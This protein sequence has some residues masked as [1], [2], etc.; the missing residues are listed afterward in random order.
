[1]TFCTFQGQALSYAVDFE[2]GLLENAEKLALH[3]FGKRFVLLTDSIVLPLY[4]RA[5]DERLKACGLDVYLASFPAGERH[6]T[7]STKER[8]EDDLLRQGFGRDTVLLALGGGAV[9]DMGGFLAS[10]YCRGIPWVA[11]PTTLLGMVDACLGGKTGVNTPFGKNLVGSIYQP[12]HLAIDPQT[13]ATL[14]LKEL[15]N[16][17]VEMIKHAC[18]KDAAYFSFLKAH[19]SHLWQRPDLLQEAIWR[20]FF[21]KKEIVELDER[22]TGERFLLN[23]GHTIGH[24]LEFAANYQMAHGEAVA[25][26]MVVEGYVA[27]KRGILEQDSFLQMWDLLKAYGLPL[28]PAFPLDFKRI[29]EALLLDKKALQKAPRLILLEAI[30]RTQ[31]G[32]CHAV[33]MEE[34]EQALH[35][36]RHDLFG[37]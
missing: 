21:I 33:M 36:M 22:E 32:F 25:I 29:K 18:I 20:A 16:G 6:K 9:T 11:L 5:L 19:A 4:G 35:W 17:I 26:G 14:P 23:F 8:L 7:R 31:A 37:H 13:L 15:Q 2:A 27:L 1:M 34:M 3:R 24:A 28:K 30:G 12:A 10:T